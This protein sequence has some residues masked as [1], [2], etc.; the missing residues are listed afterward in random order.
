[1]GNIYTFQSD[2]PKALEYFGKAL[3]ITEKIGNKR[4]KQLA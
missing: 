3:K 4:E 2:Y 1:M